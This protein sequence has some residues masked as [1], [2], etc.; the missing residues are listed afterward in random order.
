MV[1]LS[2]K[3]KEKSKN[4]GMRNGKLFTIYKDI[5]KKRSKNF[6]PQRY[7]KLEYERKRKD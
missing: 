4:K 3:E 1:T 7:G 6:L 5:T 2:T